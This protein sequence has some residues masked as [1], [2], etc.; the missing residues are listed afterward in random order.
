MDRECE[1]CRGQSFLV[2]DT[3]YASREEHC[4]N[5]KCRHYNI[6]MRV[7]V[8][9]TEQFQDFLEDMNLKKCEKCGKVDSPQVEESPYYCEVCE[10]D[11]HH[12]IDVNMDFDLCDKELSNWKEG[13]SK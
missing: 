6:E 3:H 1:M 2:E 4:L 11:P 13:M 8:K 9:T 7:G 5:D 12:I 10:L